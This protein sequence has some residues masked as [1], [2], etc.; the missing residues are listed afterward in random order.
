MIPSNVKAIFFDAVGTLIHPDPP[1]IQVYA[2]V[3]H[4][5][6]SQ[7]SVEAIKKLFHA[8][9][10]DQDRIDRAN[11][12]TTNEF[13]EAER[14][15]SIIAASLPDVIDLDRAFSELFSHFAKPSSWRC[16]MDAPP[17][18]QELAKRGY[19]LGM[20]SNFDS[21]LRQVVRGIPELSLLKHVVISSEV[22]W[23]KPSQ[24]FFDA[25]CRMV[26][27][28]A[29]QILYVGD[30]RVND[31]EGARLA[32]LKSVLFATQDDSSQAHSGIKRLRELLESKS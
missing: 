19:L 15:R 28:K 2:E 6:G 13:R 5:L 25:I 4:R 12:F 20:A 32:G 30:D 29:E 3:G 10:K 7:L 24:M 9:F 23:R 17:V 11:N 18:L 27:L 8:S 21:R 14:W 16:E 22:G 26:D 1:A 31:Y